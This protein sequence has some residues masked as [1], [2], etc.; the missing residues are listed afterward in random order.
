MGR[1]DQYLQGQREE[2]RR[3]DAAIDAR[4]QRAREVAVDL[5]SLLAREFHASRVLLFGSVVAEGFSLESDID[6]AVSG[7]EPDRYFEAWSAL[8]Q[9]SDFAVDLVVL[10]TASDSLRTVAL[11]QGVTLYDREREPNW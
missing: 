3:Q 5:A 6:L 11:S 8:S 9:A 7:L 1:W 4:R 2:I 10:E